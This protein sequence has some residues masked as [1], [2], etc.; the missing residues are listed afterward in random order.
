MGRAATDPCGHLETMSIRHI[1]IEQEP[2]RRQFVGLL[3]GLEPISRLEDLELCSSLKRLTRETAERASSS[4][5]RIICGMWQCP[6]CRAN[7][8][9]P[10]GVRSVQPPRSVPVRARPLG[11]YASNGIRTNLFAR[12]RSPDCR[13]SAVTPRMIDR[14]WMS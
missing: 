14:R 6:P 7:R 5:T 11:S 9:P 8:S 2:I 12:L 3:K 13:R 4:T 1:D 10:V